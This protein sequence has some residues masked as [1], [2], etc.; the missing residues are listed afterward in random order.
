MPSGAGRGLQLLGGELGHPD[1]GVG[2]ALAPGA[3][4]GVAVLAQGVPV[5]FG[6]VVQGRDERRPAHRVELAVDDDHARWCR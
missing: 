5:L 4:V 3:Q 1:E 2:A 6:E